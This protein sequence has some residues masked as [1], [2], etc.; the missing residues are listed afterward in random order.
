M[1]ILSLSDDVFI[2]LLHE[3]DSHPVLWFSVSKRK[4]ERKKNQNS[5][6]AVLG[7]LNRKQAYDMCTSF[8]N[9]Q[10]RYHSLEGTG[11]AI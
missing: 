10:A 7:K 1:S 2:H 9:I 11:T 3:T 8:H 5:E 4:R 6:R